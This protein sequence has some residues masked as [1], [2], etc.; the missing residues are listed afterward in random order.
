MIFNTTNETEQNETDCSVIGSRKFTFKRY[1]SRGLGDNLLFIW[2]TCL[3]IKNRKF[4][5]NYNPPYEKE[6]FFNKGFDIC[7]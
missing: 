7:Y 2:L 4:G 1:L 6:S 5:K 3:R